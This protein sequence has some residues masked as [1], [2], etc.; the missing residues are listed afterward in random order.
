MKHPASSRP[1]DDRETAAT[2]PAAVE[3]SEARRT[4]LLKLG[5]TAGV[6][7]AAPTVLRIDRAAAMRPSC[8]GGD[9]DDDGC[10]GYGGGGRRPSGPSLP[11][12]P[13][14]PSRG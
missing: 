2:E 11:S 7:Y 1:D 9:D 4:A 6:A 8:P 5:L 12:G 13:S 10:G 14:G 3:V